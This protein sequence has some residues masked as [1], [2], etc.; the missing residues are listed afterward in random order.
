MLEKGVAV[1]VAREGGVVMADEGV[2]EEGVAVR[3][4]ARNQTTEK[5]NGE[6][7][8]KRALKRPF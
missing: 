5:R 6:I 7:K 3:E 8:K 1:V 2:A 4:M